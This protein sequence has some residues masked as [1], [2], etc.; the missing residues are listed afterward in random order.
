[1]NTVLFS[2]TFYSEIKTYCSKNGLFHFLFKFVS[3]GSRIDVYCKRRPSFNGQS[4]NPE[5]THLFH[6]G[7]LCFVEGKE[8]RT[9]SRAEKLAAQWAEYFLEYRRTGKVQN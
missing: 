3:N 8:P 2:G 5:K 6:S 4:S 9:Q 7:K 1:M